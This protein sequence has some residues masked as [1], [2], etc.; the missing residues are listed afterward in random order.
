MY[1]VILMDEF[2]V[3]TCSYAPVSMHDGLNSNAWS[4]QLA[5]AYCQ[6]ASYIA[7]VLVTS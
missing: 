5:F 1:I 3:V 2:R 7:I 6:V 4:M